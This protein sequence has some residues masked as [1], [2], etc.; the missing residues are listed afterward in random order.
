MIYILFWKC[1]CQGKNKKHI[2]N[3]TM[4]NISGFYII[5]YY[6]VNRSIK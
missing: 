1:S 2:E 5:R 6:D 3:T 4:V